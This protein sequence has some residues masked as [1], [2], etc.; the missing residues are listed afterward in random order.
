MR[1]GRHNMELMSLLGSCD[2]S[3]VLAGKYDGIA[4]AYWEGEDTLP[5]DVLAELGPEVAGAM[6]AEPL[7]E[8]LVRGVLE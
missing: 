2:P 1:V 8:Y 3:H 5:E 4:R 7:H 6:P